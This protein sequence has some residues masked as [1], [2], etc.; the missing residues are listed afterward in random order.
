MIFYNYPLLNEIYKLKNGTL[1][2]FKKLR[3]YFLLNYFGY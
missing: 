1:K 2:N 3:F